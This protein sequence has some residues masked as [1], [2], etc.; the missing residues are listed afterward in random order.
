VDIAE[1][2]TLFGQWMITYSRDYFNS[3]G[4]NVIYGDTDSVF[5]ETGD[6][7]MDLETELKKYHEVLKKVLKEKYNIENSIIQLNFDKQYESLILIAKKSYTG[8][9]VNIEGKKTDDIYARGIEFIKKNTFSFASVKQKELVGLFLRQEPTY[10]DI[11]EWLHKTKEEFFKKEFTQEEL[12]ISQKMSKEPDKYK[13]ASQLHVRL[14]K[15]IKEQT[16]QNVAN[17]EISY[18][19]TSHEKN[20]DGILASDF[21]GN[22]DR[23]YYWENK[24]LPVLERIANIAFPGVELEIER[25]QQFYRDKEITID[26]CIEEQNKVAWFPIDTMPRTYGKSKVKLVRDGLITLWFI[27]WIGF[28]L[29]TRKLR[30][31]LRKYTKSQ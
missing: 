30:A 14:A 2:I 31:W 8:H 28:A 13:S 7:E 4:F 5:V 11:K 6:R 16:G 9:V 22:F 18:I 26:E 21:D 10:E 24:T 25:Q 17:T 1:S 3:I 27:F 29:R 20:M 19:I 12:T 15:Q 23:E